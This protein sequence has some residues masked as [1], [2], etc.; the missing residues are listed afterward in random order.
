MDDRPNAGSPPIVADALPFTMGG[1]VTGFRR[2]LPVALSVFAYGLVFGVLARQAG[3]G[4]GTVMLMSGTVFAGAAQFVALGRWAT[5][6]PIAGLVLTTL[7]VNLRHVLMGAALSPWLLRL[8]RPLAYGS[9]FLMADENWALTVA[10]F[11]S[12]EAN[13]GFLFGSGLAV[14]LAWFSATIIGRTAGTFLRDPAA[15]GFDF[16]FTAVFVALLSGLWRGRGDLLPWLV[17]GVVAVG[18]EVLLPGRWYI[19]LG[20]RVGGA[21]ATLRSDE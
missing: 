16:A 17:A 19:I 1:I 6:L 18:A 2:A 13:G 12:G 14:Y 8:R 7:A 21:V 3:L 15:W 9:V 5:P 10:E 4:I 11:A 20:G